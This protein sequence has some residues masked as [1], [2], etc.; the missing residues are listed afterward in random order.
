MLPARRMASSASMVPLVSTSRISLSR[1]VRCSTRAAS[2][3]VGHA[4]DRAERR[5][6]AQA[7]DGCSLFV[8][9]LRLRGRTI[10][11]AALDGQHHFQLTGAGQVGDDQLG[12]HDLDV[13][14][15][16]NIAGRDRTRAFLGQRQLGTIARVHAQGD[17]LQ[18]QQDFDDILLHTFDA[19]VL[20]QHTLDL[21]L[22]DRCARHAG[23]QD[24]A[25]SVTQRVAEAALE[26]LDDD[27]RASRGLGLHPDAARLQE[28]AD[29]FLHFGS[30][31]LLTWSR[32]RPRGS[33]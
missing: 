31:L 30:P 19:G 18:V 21:G 27:A 13:V 23:Q 3:V 33:R 7:T 10:A 11:A 25:Q 15:V 28:F 14:I 32:A 26:G 29:G 20:V 8:T 24:T 17:V 5:V 2:T 16:S 6:Q 12:V 1:S 9:F 22:Y 4:T